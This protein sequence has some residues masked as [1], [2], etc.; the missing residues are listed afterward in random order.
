VK[1]E[2]A[3][4]VFKYAF[5]V[6]TAIVVIGPFFLTIITS[7]KN[8]SDLYQSGPLA[9]PTVWR[10][11]NYIKIWK[12]VDFATFYLNSFIATSVSALGVVVLSTLGAYPFAFL[13]FSLKRFWWT[14]I[15]LGLLIPV[16][17]IIIPFFKDMKVLGLLNSRW[18]LILQLVSSMTAFG[19]FLIRSFMKDIPPSLLESARMDGSSEFRNLVSIVIPL[20]RQ[21]LTS[22]FIFAAM[23]SWNAYFAPLILIQREKLRTVPIGLDYFRQQ[24]TSDYPL[25]SAA[26]LTAIVPIL[27]VYLVFQRRIVKGMTIGALKE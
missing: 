20:T 17:M 22:L 23:W 8:I 19:I 18:A 6:A 9:M 11:G 5:L 26:A 15:I 2:R 27:I 16:E 13:T 10:F 12:E 1:W 24:F 4:S 25:V 7:L 3:V 21:S 14:I